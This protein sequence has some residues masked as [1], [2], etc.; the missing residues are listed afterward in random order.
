M[1]PRCWE[2]EFCGALRGRWRR[3]YVYLNMEKRENYTLK[4]IT[5]YFSPWLDDLRSHC[6][7]YILIT[8]IW[9]SLSRTQNIKGTSEDPYQKKENSTTP[10]PKKEEGEDST[11]WGKR[12]PFLLKWPAL[13]EIYGAKSKRV[14]GTRILLVV[15]NSLFLKGY[16]LAQF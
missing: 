5:V 8:G 2:M 4:W 14:L 6:R 15:I 1:P 11:K 7:R 16:N 9:K 10:S 3:M 12:N 13:L